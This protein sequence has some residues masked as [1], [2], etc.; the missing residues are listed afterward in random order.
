LILSTETGWSHKIKRQHDVHGSSHELVGGVGLATDLSPRTP[1]GIKYF[2]EYGYHLRGPS[3]LNLQI[4]FTNGSPTTCPV[5]LCDDWARFEGRGLEIAAGAKIKWSFGR[6]LQTHLKCGLAAE[7]I[8][9]DAYAGAAGGLRVGGGLR[10]FVLESVG[11]GGEAAAVFG[12]SF[13][14]R[15]RLVPVDAYVAVDVALGVELRF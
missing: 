1:G 5:Q 15:R 10:Y 7:L 12:P 13:L 14:H 2:A 3:W 8:W 4:N 6:A 9:F 11:I